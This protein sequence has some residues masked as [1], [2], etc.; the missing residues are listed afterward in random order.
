M[1]LGPIANN[2]ARAIVRIADGTDRP[3]SMDDCTRIIAIV[4]QAINDSQSPG[5]KDITH[6][7]SACCLWEFVSDQTI[8]GIENPN[9]AI[10]ATLQNFGT[11]AVRLFCCEIAGAASQAWD[12]VHPDHFDMPFD[13][14]FCPAFITEC[15][16]WDPDGTAMPT[17]RSDFMDIVAARAAAWHEGS[18]AT[19]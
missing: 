1:K 16:E 8:I 13:W 6:R 2:A 18:P 4:Q 17:L 15:V 19:V 11:C 12:S 9:P 7:E 14:H 3:L 5:T 10:V